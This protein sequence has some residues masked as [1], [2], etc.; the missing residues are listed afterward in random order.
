[1]KFIP[2]KYQKYAIEHIIENK[3]AGLFLDMGCG[4]QNRYN[5]Y[6]TVGACL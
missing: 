5:T 4:R 1:M 2:H 6:G 3:T